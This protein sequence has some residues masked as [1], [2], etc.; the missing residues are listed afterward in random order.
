MHKLDKN[1]SEVLSKIKYFLLDLD[2]TLYLEEKPIGDMANTLDYLRAKGK[3][4]V[5]LTNN[6][7]RSTDVYVERLKKFGFYKEG[8]LVYSSG[9]ATIEYLD[10]YH[11]GKKVYLLGTDDMKKEMAD[12]GIN[13]TEEVDAEIAVMS[14]D[15]ELSYEKLCNFLRNV[16]FGATYIATHPD[17]SCP[18][19]GVYVPDVGS[20]IKMIEVAS[21][22]LPSLIIGKPNDIMGKNLKAR[23]NE[24]SDDAF[25]MVG[26]RLY[27]DIAFGKN[28]NFYAMLVM[29][30][31]T[32]EDMIPSATKAPDFIL[33]SLNDITSYL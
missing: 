30:G 17:N 18:A 32:T 20:F 11:K 23:F 29:S 14:Y 26:D 15:T 24:E 12:N 21:G 7:S 2:G 33:A 31:E 10:R 16:H 27:T 28:C 5:Y 1:L 3:K 6:S 8:D 4:L 25:I 19:K 13:L 22:Y 9:L